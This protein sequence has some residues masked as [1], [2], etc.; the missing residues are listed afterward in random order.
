[1]LG[2]HT[3]K[4]SVCRFLQLLSHHSVVILEYGQHVALISIN[5]STKLLIMQEAAKNCKIN[6]L[7]ITLKSVIK[8][9]FIIFTS[10]KTYL[11]S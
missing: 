8:F 6:S 10:T 7:R 9:Y 4:P 3:F 11:G 2:V 1:M 5:I